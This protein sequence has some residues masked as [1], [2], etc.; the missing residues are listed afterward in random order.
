MHARASR[1]LQIIFK[2]WQDFMLLYRRVIF[3]REN[4][5]LSIQ[6]C[7]DRQRRGPFLLVLVN[8]A[9]ANVEGA[10][11]SEVEV[12]SSS[13]EHPEVESPDP[14]EFPSLVFLGPSLLSPIA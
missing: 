14:K 13:D 1:G 9:A 12:S 3:R 2:E 10:R 7:V 6:S 4:V 8:T 5:P 11:L